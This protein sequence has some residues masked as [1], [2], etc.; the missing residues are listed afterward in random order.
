[1]AARR[2]SLDS[3]VWQDSNLRHP[4]CGRGVL[5]TELQTL[6]LQRKGARPRWFAATSVRARGCIF[7]AGQKGRA[8][9]GGG[10]RTLFAQLMRLAYVPSFA[11]KLC[12]RRDSNPHRPRFVAWRPIH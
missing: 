9:T 3:C 7:Y 12:P 2:R 11:G 4:R 10:N 6:F 5:A 8:G 1:M